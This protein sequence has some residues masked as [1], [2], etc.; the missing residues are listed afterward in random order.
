MLSKMP[1]HSAVP[2]AS[3]RKR[4]RRRKGVREKTRDL[5]CFSYYFLDT[6]LRELAPRRE[7]GAYAGVG[8]YATVAP[9]T[10]LRPG[11]NFTP[12]RQLLP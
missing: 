12:R 8:A 9:A 11:V 3:I 1:E 4:R 10:I 2:A 7:F 6:P 5:F